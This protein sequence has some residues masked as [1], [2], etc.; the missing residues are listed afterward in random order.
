M[1]KRI[2]P[3]KGQDVIFEIS[4]DDNIDSFT[5]TFYTTTPTSGVVREMTDIKEGN[6]IKINASELATLDNGLLKC[7]A[8]T[9]TED[10]DFND[11]EYDEIEIIDTDFY[12]KN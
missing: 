9:Q 11:D 5:L 12:I 10:S 2:Y 4:V 8:H 1:I 7:M 6:L 3:S